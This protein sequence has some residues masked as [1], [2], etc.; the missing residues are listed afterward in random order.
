MLRPR[1]E[2]LLGSALLLA[3]CFRASGATSDTTWQARQAEELRKSG[4]IMD[5]ANKQS[6]L[7]ARYRFMRRPGAYVVTF[8]D[9]KGRARGDTRI[10]VAGK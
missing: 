5:E 10:T 2:L 7:L 8:Q 9:E 6:G 4:A 3:C 1:K